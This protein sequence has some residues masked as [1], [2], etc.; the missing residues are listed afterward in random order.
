M[1]TLETEAIAE[2]IAPP[3]TPKK[4]DYRSMVWLKYEI[5]GYQRELETNVADFVRNTQKRK[6]SLRESLSGKFISYKKAKETE[7]L[8]ALVKNLLEEVQKKTEVVEEYEKKKIQLYSE[9]TGEPGLPTTT[10]TTEEEQP[11]TTATKA[12]KPVHSASKLAE[13]G[14]LFGE[15]I[16]GLSGKLEEF[17]EF[18]KV[19]NPTIHITT[20][21]RFKL[22]PNQERVA[23]ITPVH[24]PFLRLQ[25]K[26]TSMQKEIKKDIDY[27][28]CQLK[29]ETLL[30][31][32][33]EIA[34]YFRTHD[35]MTVFLND[36]APQIPENEGLADDAKYITWEIV[37]EYMYKVL[38]PEPIPQGVTKKIYSTLVGNTKRRMTADEFTDLFCKMHYRALKP[39]VMTT[40]FD[41][42][43]KPLKKV[44]RLEVGEIVR[45]IGD[46]KKTSSGILRFEA[47]TVVIEGDSGDKTSTTE[48]VVQTGWVSLQGQ[49]GSEFFH[50]HT[51]GYK[52]VKQTV[53]TDIFEMKGF[54]P[55]VRLQIGDQVRTIGFPKREPTSNL[56]RVKAITV[57]HKTGKDFVGY[58]TVE[59][60]QNSVYLE[61]VDELIFPETECESSPLLTKNEA[62]KPPQLELAAESKDELTAT[63]DAALDITAADGGDVVMGE[64][65]TTANEQ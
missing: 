14:K 16:M 8:Q 43:T 22:L 17:L 62:G 49:K 21:D 48:G 15:S 59:G 29:E 10:T 41:V 28:N 58:V 40:E 24:T 46:V 30:R 32:R 53:L 19:N 47:Q 60:N 13:L 64:A 7:E 38:Q 39:H 36:L 23:I 57:G 34:T 12:E 44:K 55:V 27:T 54:K 4:E 9:I 25:T 6:I 51:P 45:L 5:M 50:L 11:T 33:I 52:V 20:K 56:V 1:E 37:G 65:P 35:P 18:C 63:L 42:E 3:P 31:S 2:T 61:P 26:L